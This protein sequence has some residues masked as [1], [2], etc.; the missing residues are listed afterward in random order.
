M[1]A[2]ACHREHDRKADGVNAD[3]ADATGIGSVDAVHGLDDLVDRA[4]SEL[5]AE[6][7]DRDLLVVVRR[8][9]R[10]ARVMPSTG[11]E[12][13]R[14]RSSCATGAD[15]SPAGGPGVSGIHLPA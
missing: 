1:V 3:L 5:V 14:T 12:L 6:D 2:D 10:I 15:E 8:T 7:V 4:T 11:L 13:L 9:L